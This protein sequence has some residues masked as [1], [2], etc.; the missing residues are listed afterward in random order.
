MT[1]QHRIIRALSDLAAEWDTRAADLRSIGFSITW[2]GRDLPVAKKLR[3]I[4]A[5]ALAIGLAGEYDRRAAE[6]RGII[7][8]IR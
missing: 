5:A 7:E 8:G 1:T 4:D 3:L 2:D 6:L